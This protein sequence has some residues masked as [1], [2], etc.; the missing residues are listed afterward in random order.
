MVNGAQG[1]LGKDVDKM[2]RL[3]V[4]IEFLP[5]KD[6]NI[7]A[8]FIHDSLTDLALGLGAEHLLETFND[9]VERKYDVPAGFI[10]K[11]VANFREKVER[12]WKDYLVMASIN[13]TGFLVN[14]I[15]IHN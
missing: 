10:T 5:F 12:G 11:N 7:G 2:I 4:D 6:L 1:I 8:I 14:P 15:G 3:L 9:H 13:K